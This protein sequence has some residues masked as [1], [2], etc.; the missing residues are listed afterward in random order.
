MPNGLEVRRGRVEPIGST[1]KVSG[2]EH[3]V[4]SI[5]VTTFELN[6]CVV[7]YS[8]G[9]LPFRAGDE[10]IVAGQQR[11]DGIFYAHAVRL[12]RQGV[13]LDV[14]DGTLAVRLFGAVFFL[15]GCG[16]VLG[17]LWQLLTI[18]GEPFGYGGDLFPI[19]IT[20]VLGAAFSGAGWYIA[21][22]GRDRTGSTARAML[23][24]ATVQDSRAGLAAP[25][26]PAGL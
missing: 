25:A 6:G 5:T 11:A 2:G 7:S 14:G 15:I 16:L 19:F 4:S 18:D 23:D 13:T 3:H 24:T 10:A 26:M 9:T 20:G 12:P 21:Q 22:R 8:G 17:T 1:I